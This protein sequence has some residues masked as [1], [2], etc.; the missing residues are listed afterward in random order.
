MEHLGSVTFMLALS[1]L[2]AIQ[3]FQTDSPAT[4]EN[5]AAQALAAL[6]F[7]IQAHNLFF[8]LEFNIFNKYYLFLK[9]MRAT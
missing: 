6:K 8:S 9:S 5:L 3:Q 2:S 4:N 7:W 1:L